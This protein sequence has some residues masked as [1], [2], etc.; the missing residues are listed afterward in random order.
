MKKQDVKMTHYTLLAVMQVVRARRNGVRL[1]QLDWENIQAGITVKW[2]WTPA[3]LVRIRIVIFFSKLVDLMYG[4]RGRRFLFDPAA[5]FL[6]VV[7][8]G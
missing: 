6:G 5:V 7:G 3:H 1:I 4:V 2:T 8:L